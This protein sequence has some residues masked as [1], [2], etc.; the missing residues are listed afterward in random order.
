MH[1]LVVLLVTTLLCQ[2]LLA[3]DELQASFEFKNLQNNK[4]VEVLRKDSYSV[5][6]LSYSGMLLASKP[7][8]GTFALNIACRLANARGMQYFVI[9][10]NKEKTAAIDELTVG[11][12]NNKKTKIKKKW[13][14]LLTEST[15]NK[16]FDYHAV[17]KSMERFFDANLP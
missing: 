14:K 12:T 17:C 13:K 9:L 3:D 11:L 7:S 5:V 1:R 15:P 16:L 4:A 6:E 8:R 2:T 10:G